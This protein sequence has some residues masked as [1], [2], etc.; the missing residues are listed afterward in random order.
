[1]NNNYVIYKATNLVNGKMYVGKTYNFEKRKRE[2]I[3]D[4]DD[5]CP[6]HRALKKYG[7][8]NFKWEIIDT[9]SS[10]EEICD[11]EKYWIKT[12]RTCVSEKNSQGYNV[13]LGGEGGVAWNSIPI[14]QFNLDGNFIAKH[15][16]SIQASTVTGAPRHGINDVV[17]GKCKQAGGFMW[18]REDEWDGKPIQPFTPR[19]SHRRK[20][21]VQLDANGTMI[22]IFESV[23]IASDMTKTRRTAIS[24]AIDKDRLANGFKWVSLDKYNPMEDYSYKGIKFSYKIV[25]LDG[26][27]NK[28][29][30]YNNCSEAARQN[31]WAAKVHK[32][33]NKAVH[34]Q[35]MFR[36]FYWDKVS[37]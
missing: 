21:L 22:N 32:Q 1:M 11:K 16:S 10:D 30:E 35:R 3:Y 4:I 25:K 37:C 7:L 24:D 36:G 23:Q 31:G 33:I 19:I 28:V 14:I 13:T 6:F 12:L 5:N 18:M 15:K 9:A 8:E 27:K 26:N 34:E 2:H 17:R 29:A 20:P